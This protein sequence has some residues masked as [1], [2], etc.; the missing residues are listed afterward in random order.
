[1][2]HSQI[3]PV[4]KI[5]SKVENILLRK[6]IA[7]ILVEL[8]TFFGTAEGLPTEGREKRYLF[9]FSRTSVKF[10]FPKLSVSL[11]IVSQIKS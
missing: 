9:L 1:M 5:G 10:C 7:L 3:N 4:S 6:L 2:S 8:S 11:L